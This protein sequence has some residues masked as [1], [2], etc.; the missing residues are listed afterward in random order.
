MEESV[1]GTTEDRGN[2]S[3][4]PGEA[5][6]GDGVTAPNPGEV[7]GEDEQF[8][9]MLDG[10]HRALGEAVMAMAGSRTHGHLFLSDML[11]LVLPAV[12]LRQYKV[13][14]DNGGQTVGYLSWA[15]L[16]EGTLERLKGGGADFRLKPSEWNDGELACVMDVCAPSAEAGAKMVSLLK[17]EVFGGRDLLVFRRGGSGEATV[18]PA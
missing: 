16:S 4:Q 14:R 12:S 11:W 7:S 9:R 8:R 2:G 13:V 15:L 10:L 3:S 17:S 18:T 6:V 1:K 5:G